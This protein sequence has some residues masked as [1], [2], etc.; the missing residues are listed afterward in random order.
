L[1][2]RPFPNVFRAHVGGDHPA[3]TAGATAGLRAGRDAHRRACRIELAV[4]LRETHKNAWARRGDAALDAAERDALDPASAGGTFR[5]ACVA[6]WA[7]RDREDAMRLLAAMAGA[8]ANDGL[9]AAID[10]PRSAISGSRHG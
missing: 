4:R 1:E 2:T 9:I 5:E 6:P 7:G 10:G 8:W 3:Q